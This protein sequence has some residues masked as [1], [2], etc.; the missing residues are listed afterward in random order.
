MLR[1]AKTNSITGLE[2]AVTVKSSVIGQAD[3]EVVCDWSGS[4]LLEYQREL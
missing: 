3:W 2:E 4:V 1:L